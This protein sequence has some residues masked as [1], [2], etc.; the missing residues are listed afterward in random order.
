MEKFPP[1]FNNTIQPNSD[2]FLW[3]MY[4]LSFILQFLD[5]GIYVKFLEG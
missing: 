3:K 2:G 4:L 1:K 5:P